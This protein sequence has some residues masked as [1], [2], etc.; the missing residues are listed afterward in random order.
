MGKL[1]ILFRLLAVTAIAYCVAQSIVIWSNSEADRFDFLRLMRAKGKLPAGH[2]NEVQFHP[3]PN[4]DQMAWQWRLS[5][6][7]DY[8]FV[9]FLVDGMIASDA[10]HATDSSVQLFESDE[11][12]IFVGGEPR[13]FDFAIAIAKTRGG[14]WKV[15]VRNDARLKTYD[16]SDSVAAILDDSDVKFELVAEQQP[17][18]LQTDS[19]VLLFRLRSKTTTTA[20]EFAPGICWYLVPL[21]KKESISAQLGRATK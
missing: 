8:K 2:E 7:G 4:K 10:P 15:H 11:G 16:V 6:P 19:P 20:T 18:Y 17:R 13:E 14:L 21:D 1:K 5:V 12:S 9:S 3:V